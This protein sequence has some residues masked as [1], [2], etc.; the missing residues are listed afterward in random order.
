MLQD[1]I[2]FS[3]LKQLGLKILPA[4]DIHQ[5]SQDLDEFSLGIE[6]ADSV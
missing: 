2:Q 4:G 3:G 6:P 5:I 1:I